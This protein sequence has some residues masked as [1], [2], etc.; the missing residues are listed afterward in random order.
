MKMKTLRKI[1]LLLFIMST[2]LAFADIWVPN[3]I[4]GEEKYNPDILL[5][6]LKDEFKNGAI[7]TVLQ[8]MYEAGEEFVTDLVIK[9]Y[10]APFIV[11][12]LAS[13]GNPEKIAQKIYEK[14][15]NEIDDIFNDPNSNDAQKAAR[16]LAL[17]EKDL[18]DYISETA[19][20]TSLAAKYAI[21][22]RTYKLNWN[23]QQKNK[24]CDESYYEA[25]FKI[26]NASA[27][28]D[29][30]SFTYVPRYEIYLDYDY[31]PKF[32]TY[33]WEPDYKVYRINNGVEKLITT[34]NG[35]QKATN[36]LDLGDVWDEIQGDV[37]IPENGLIFYDY[38]SDPNYVN[39]ETLSYKVETSTAKYYPWC[40]GTSITTSLLVVDSDGD[41]DPDFVPWHVLH[42]DILATLIVINTILL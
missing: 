9:G 16:I 12:W 13:P 24:I 21:N 6:A 31:K 14:F 19:G 35:Y 36:W 29:Y 42:E 22:F 41:G 4:T 40:S 7:L 38:D 2:P 17:I 1:I 3:E 25:V 23:R 30:F 28:F 11:D 8:S 20:P 32:V 5:P 39:G 37:Y 15:G 33:Y 18:A 10:I 34:I 26:C 27:C